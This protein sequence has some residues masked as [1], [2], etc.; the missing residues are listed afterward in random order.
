M[1]GYTSW[2]TPLSYIGFK[3]PLSFIK[4]FD[5]L[6]FLTLNCILRELLVV[7]V[8]NYV[9]GVLTII[10]KE[11]KSQRLTEDS[12]VSSESLGPQYREIK[13]QNIIFIGVRE[14]RK[15][16]VDTGSMWLHDT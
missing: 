7:Y 6:A 8:K 14:S 3:L 11:S 4:Y 15:Y 12:D 2:I 16:I 9:K 13:I 5:C 10:V 1:F